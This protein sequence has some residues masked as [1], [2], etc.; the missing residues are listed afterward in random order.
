MRN[1][2]NK[3]C[4]TT[5]ITVSAVAALLC[6]AAAMGSLSGQ[7]SSGAWTMAWDVSQA[8]EDW[9]YSYTLTGVGGVDQIILDTP[10]FSGSLMPPATYVGPF[11]VLVGA[12]DYSSEGA[13]FQGLSSLDG[14]LTLSFTS[15]EAPMWGNFFAL[16]GQ[17]VVAY[18]ADY[19]V[20]LGSAALYDYNAD[21]GVSKILVPDMVLM[22]PIV[23]PVPAP[24]AALLVVIGLGL[25]G[26]L[27]RRV[28]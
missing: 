1:L 8:G 7:V 15:S 28:A 17:S 25:V 10:G 23:P 12:A 11:T 20:A 19:A 14:V 13:S 18:N 22:L 5:A 4:R 21:P 26:W 24:A 6:P 2:E 9:S 3:L 16:S 27:K